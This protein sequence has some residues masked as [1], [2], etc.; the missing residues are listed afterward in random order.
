MTTNIIFGLNKKQIKSYLIP[1]V[2]GYWSPVEGAPEDD[3][4]L[5]M[6]PYWSTALLPNLV[7]GFLL[8]SKPRSNLA[9]LNQQS[10]RQPTR[11]HTMRFEAIDRF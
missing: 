10:T 6:L 4:S 11:T 5:F 1:W 9:R 7:W 3:E 8:L 2:V